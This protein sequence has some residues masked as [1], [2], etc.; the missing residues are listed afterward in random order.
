[1]LILKFLWIFKRSGIV[2][3]SLGRRTK[4]GEIALSDT[5]L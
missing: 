3:H 1:M 5:L 4:M 2:I